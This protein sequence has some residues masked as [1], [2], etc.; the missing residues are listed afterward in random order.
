[1]KAFILARVS[2]ITQDYE[3]QVAEPRNVVSSRDYAIIE[4]IL[5]KS[6]RETPTMKTVLTFQRLISLA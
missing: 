5:S 2:K 4:E 1:M 6:I 3:R